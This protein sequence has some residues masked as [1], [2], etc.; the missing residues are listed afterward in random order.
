MALGR[1]VPKAFH[2]VTSKKY[3]SSTWSNSE[4]DPGTIVYVAPTELSNSWCVWP[5][6]LFII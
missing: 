5:I 2:V 6:N 4:V 3:F 1:F